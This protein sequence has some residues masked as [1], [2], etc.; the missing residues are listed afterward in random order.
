M[1]SRLG[2]VGG[3]LFAARYQSTSPAGKRTWYSIS[4]AIL[5]ISIVALPV[6]GLA[7]GIAGRAGVMLLV[8]GGVA[9]AASL[10]GREIRPACG[11]RRTGSRCRRLP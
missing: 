5:L 6:R 2:N 4:G 9:L 3:R 8:S 7:W 11:W 1:M 10:S